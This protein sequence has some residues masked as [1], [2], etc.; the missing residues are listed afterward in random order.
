M[1][2]NRKKSGPRQSIGILDEK[3]LH[4]SLKDWY[5]RPG[6]LLEV[7]VDGFHIDIKRP[8]LLIEIQTGN[9]SSLKR[10]LN[11]LVAKHPLRLVYPIPREKWIVRLGPDG[12]TRLGRR[13]SPKKEN[14]FQL[15]IE[16]V[17][18]PDLITHPNFS[19]EVLLIQEEEIRCND[20]NGSRRRKGVSIADRRLIAV[21]NQYRFV[22][23]SEFL[24][25]IPPD[26]HEPFRS[27]F[28]HVCWKDLF[29]SQSIAWRRSSNTFTFRPR[30]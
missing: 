9:F 3:S 20:G 25:F 14:V 24:S 30:L 17:S 21:L 16:L 5:A 2:H 19:L 13:K 8:H 10:K 29:R 15:F 6:D 11:A 28:L 1:E 4:A 23:P 18:I 7:E 27:T 26:L 22:K 12:L